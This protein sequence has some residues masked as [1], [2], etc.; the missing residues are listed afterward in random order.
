MINKFCGSCGAMDFDKKKDICN[1]S[2]IYFGKNTT[3]IIAEYIQF[4]ELKV[5]HYNTIGKKG[6][7]CYICMRC[8]DMIGY[9]TQRRDSPIIKCPNCPRTMLFDPNMIKIK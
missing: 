5:M 7:D 2:E 9:I 3:K 1:V 8:I 6:E 4:S